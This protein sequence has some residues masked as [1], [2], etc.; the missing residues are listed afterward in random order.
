MGMMTM[1]MTIDAAESTEGIATMTT[2][3][4]GK[5]EIPMTTMM[6]IMMIMMMTTTESEE[7][8]MMTTTMIMMMTMAESEETPMMTTTMIM[9][10]MTMTRS[11]KQKKMRCQGKIQTIS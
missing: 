4:N 8:P 10:M 9:M 7:T 5:R 2:T 6:T 1:T 11:K 3:I